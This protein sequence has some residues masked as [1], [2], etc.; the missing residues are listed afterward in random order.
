M[1]NNNE[2][3]S[4]APEPGRWYNITLGS[5]FKDNHHSDHAPKFCTFRYDFKPASI[6][7]SQPGSLHKTKDNRITVEFQNNQH[8][9]PKAVFEGVSEEYKDS[10]AVL[11]FDSETF[12]LERLH[13]AVK[14]LRYVRLPGDP[15]AGA[16]ST[17][18][19]MV[20][21]AVESHSPHVGTGLKIQPPNAGIIHETVQVEQIDIG[22]STSLEPEIE[23]DVEHSSHLPYLSMSPA[24][25]KKLESE[26][27]VD[28]VND[29]DDTSEIAKRGSASEKEFRSGLNIDI[30]LPVDIDDEIADVDV[31][32]DEADKGP[33]AAEA[34]RAQVN[35]EGR[36][37]QSSSSS[38]SSE[39]ESSDTGSGSGSGSG[40]VSSSSDSESSNCGSVNSI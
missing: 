24:D 13:R 1:S 11:F 27:H 38:S 26:E 17:M 9:K 25:P 19:T 28:I 14:R 32:D 40:S 34:L 21:P 18:S 5:S 2:D 35:A 4:S 33:N 37:Q 7:S 8:G 30:N 39:S 36:K 12:R 29:N 20:V 22:N 31:S 23:K 6:D 3:P 15:A 10:D 16:A